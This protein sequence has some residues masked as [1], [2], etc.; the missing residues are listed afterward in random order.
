VFGYKLKDKR[1]RCGIKMDAGAGFDFKK[2]VVV[3]QASGSI[4]HMVS[5]KILPYQ[6]LRLGPPGK[7]YHFVVPLL[8]ASLR[9]RTSFARFRSLARQS[10]GEI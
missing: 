4:A 7:G 5:P 3:G 6:E 8:A 2:D 10:V 1:R 9:I